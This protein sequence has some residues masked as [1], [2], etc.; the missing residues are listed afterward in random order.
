M[1]LVI[2]GHPDSANLKLAG[3]RV[4]VCV[5][6]RHD[7]WPQFRKQKRKFLNYWKKFQLGL[8][9][10]DWGFGSRQGLGIILFTTAS[11]P[12][13]GST[14]PP[15][16]WVPGALSLAVQRPGREADHSHSS[17]EVRNAWSC[18]SIPTIYLR[19]VVFS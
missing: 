2:Q 7:P 13:L 1:E 16:Q 17:A 11:K 3:F 15:I 14:Q 10:D 8:G 12:A 18:I 6:I 5:C 9:L 19:G 4:H